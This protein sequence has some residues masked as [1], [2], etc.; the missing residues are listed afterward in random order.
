[1]KSKEKSSVET[2]SHHYSLTNDKQLHSK[3]KNN[4]R[5]LKNNEEMEKVCS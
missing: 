2:E 5:I 1:M 4:S 3:L